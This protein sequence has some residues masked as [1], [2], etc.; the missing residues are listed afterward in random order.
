MA[1][2]AQAA[3]VWPSWHTVPS[4]VQMES[5]HVHDAVVPFTMHSWLAPHI[6]VVTQAVH[7]LACTLQVCTPAAAHWVA[8]AVQGLS[9]ATVPPSP[10]PP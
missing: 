5:G 2:L 8:P 6:V 1:F 9:H 3:T 7:P 4:C 10:L